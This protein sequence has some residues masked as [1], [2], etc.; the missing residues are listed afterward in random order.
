MQKRKFFQGILLWVVVVVIC[1][2][3]RYPLLGFSVPIVMISAILFSS[4]KGRFF[5]GNFCPRGA[6]FDRIFDKISLNKKFALTYTQNKCFRWT[7]FVLLMGFMGFRLSQNI[8]NIYHWGKTFWLMCVI[9]TALGIVL[10][11]IFGRRTWCSFCPIGTLTSSIKLSKKVLLID[12][13]K[14]IKCK[15]CEKKCPLNLI[16]IDALEINNKDCLKCMECVF[17]CPKKAIEYKK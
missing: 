17:D 5:C 3:H 8:G 13:E 7:I 16:N 14:C 11:I 12:E 6:F 15:L 2:G 4:F 1:F 9:T 10:A